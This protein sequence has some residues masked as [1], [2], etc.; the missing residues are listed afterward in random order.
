MLGDPR[1]RIQSDLLESHSIL[2]CSCCSQRGTTLLPS[3]H[4]TSILWVFP[5][6]ITCAHIVFLSILL[7]LNTNHLQST[8]THEHIPYLFFLCINVSYKEDYIGTH[9]RKSTLMLLTS[10]IGTNLSR[11]YLY[12]GIAKQNQ[13]Q[14]QLQ[15]RRNGK[16][17]A[18]SQNHLLKLQFSILFWYSNCL[19]KRSWLMVNLKE[20]RKWKQD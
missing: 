18:K 4:D 3:M 11:R 19:L 9:W 1:G 7:S 6:F 13:N 5:Y 10:M 15:N 14:R 12:H 2:N 20:S 16:K 17:D 8:Y